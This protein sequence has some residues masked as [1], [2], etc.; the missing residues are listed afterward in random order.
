MLFPALVLS[1]AAHVQT[2]VPIVPVDYRRVTIQDQF[3]SPR[4]K[5][6]RE[7]TMRQ[8][9]EMLEQHHYLANFE[10]AAARESGGYK[11]LLFNDSDIY[12]V[13]EAAS[14]V[15][16]KHPD[17]WLDKKVDEWIEVIG[18]AQEPDGYLN[19][20][21]QLTAPKEKWTNIRDK[22]EMYCAGHL[23]EAAAEHYKAT[24][25]RNFLDIAV[26][27]ADHLDA[28]FGEG[29]IPAYE[30]HPEPELAL[31]KLAD[32]T[33]D[34]KYARLAELFLNRRG[35]KFFAA[36]H[37]TPLDSYNGDYWSDNHMIR[38]H[39]EIVGHA[40]RAAYLFSGAADL[41][42]RKPDP[43]MNAMLD[44]VWR[45]TTERRMFVTGGLGPSG[46][47]EGFTVDY[48]LPTFTAY[49]ESCASIA[50][51]LWNY[52]LLQL[53]AQSKY[54]DVMENA[55][56]NGTLAGINL[57]G[58]KY[59]YVNP[60]ASYGTH[61]RQ[62]WFECACCPPNLARLIGQV[63]GMAYAASHSSI[64]VNLYIGG[65]VQVR[66]SGMDADLSV[67]TNYP[68]DGKVEITVQKVSKNF[69]LKLRK[70]GW[71]NTEA[72]VDGKTVTAHEDGYFVVRRSWK[73]GDRVV[74]DLPMSVRKVIS[75]PR[76]QATSGM[77]AIARGPLIYCAEAADNPKGVHQ[78]IVPVESEPQVVNET[79][80]ILGRI[81]SIKIPAHTISDTQ[82]G[83]N[84]F[85]EVPKIAPAI[86]KAIPYC[87]W[88]NRT[89]GEMAVWFS[90]TPSSLVHGHEKGAK[91]ALSFTSHICDP[92]GVVDGF[93]PVTSAEK[94]PR[95]THFWPHKGGT[96]WIELTLAKEE[97]VDSSRIFWFDD[98]G[99]GECRIPKAYRI[100]AWRRNEW[101]PVTLQNGQKYGTKLD[102]WNE[103][104]FDPVRTTKLRLVIDQ[105]DKWSSGVH[106]WQIF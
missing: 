75:H 35:E 44:R 56:Y 3:W 49:Q 86:L 11:G 23:F 17:A 64:Y 36:E 81:V 16:A 60:L 50:N 2:S 22:H 98:T 32:A 28:K 90:S 94:S 40:V 20:Y 104:K 7:T 6:L 8:Q 65:S 78:L 61:H 68:W 87:M 74:L 43:E 72:K 83:D 67:K 91:V 66:E 25:K 100:E 27:F 85:Q 103:I 21:F 80:P 31:F 30:G 57:K 93:A 42:L 34:Q 52:R 14:F 51:S 53:H 48:D 55:L 5:A 79:E 12:K 19:T 1:M 106:E 99:V 13:L 26:K 38:D 96:E 58:D 77:F 54:A 97:V 29:K 15:L 69:D 89:S 18:R 71:L 102:S 9:F 63:G 62:P 59:F 10:R 46:T 95:Q 24:G 39:D 47:N 73:A 105:Q 70:P 82:W 88:D 33:G 41:A 45:N 92:E 37:K 101:V 84:L 76:V 4:Q